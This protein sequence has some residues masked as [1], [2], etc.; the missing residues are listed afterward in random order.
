MAGC[1]PFPLNRDQPLQMPILS[2]RLSSPE[3]V[4]RLA[5]FITALGPWGPIAFVALFV[6]TTVLCLPAGI[7]TLAGGFLFGPAWGFLYVWIAS[8]LGASAAF[9]VSR[10][11]ARDWIHRRLSQRPVLHA[12]EQAVSEEGWKIV[13]LSRLAP[14]S[15]FFLLNYLYG[16]TRVRFRDYFWSTAIAMI[17][18]SFLIVYL[19][20]LGNLALSG[21]A[22][23]PMEWVLYGVGL[24]AL[25]V[26][27]V[28]IARRANRVLK[29]RLT[30]TSTLPTPRADGPR[31]RP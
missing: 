29:D 25:G 16:V 28:I 24:V 2:V 30:R 18:G 14:G 21:R 11:L 19:G 15:P 27:V 4:S 8:C 3:L 5:D 6:I 22:R 31:T 23:S 26:A 10:F 13:A 7:L 1:A 12:I 17:P 9:G 20:S